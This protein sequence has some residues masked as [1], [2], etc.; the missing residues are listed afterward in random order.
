MSEQSSEDK[1]YEAFESLLT[2][3]LDGQASRIERHMDKVETRLSEDIRE[4][5]A[6]CQDDIDRIEARVTFQERKSQRDTLIG[7]AISFVGAVLV[8]IFGGTT[9]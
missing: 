5:K 2:K 8:S 9:N 3:Y 4:V 1:R 7:S 6:D